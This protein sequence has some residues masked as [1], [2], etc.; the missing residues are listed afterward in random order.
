MDAIYAPEISALWQEGFPGTYKYRFTALIIF[1]NRS[2]VTTQN[3]WQ[4]P[5]LCDQGFNTSY[6]RQYHTSLSLNLSNE[7]YA[8]IFFII[9]LLK[10]NICLRVNKACQERLEC[11]EKEVLENLVLRYI[12]NRGII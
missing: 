3:M 10:T 9:M 1:T 6:Y 11:Q 8:F 2:L 4:I 7:A 12:V 5:N